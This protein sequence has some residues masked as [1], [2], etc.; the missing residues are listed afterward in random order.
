MVPVCQGAQR[1]VGGEVGAEQLLLRRGDPH[2]YARVEHDDVPAAELVAVVPGAWIPGGGA[3][4]LPVGRS[5]GAVVLVR[6]DGRPG[7]RLKPPPRRPVTIGEVR[8]DAV[9]P[10]HVV[11]GGEDRAGDAVEQGGG[12][13]VPLSVAARDVARAD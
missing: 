13:L 7:A 5:P 2:V 8:G 6:A 3:E 9:R 10:V 4:V 11:A 12:R 1:R